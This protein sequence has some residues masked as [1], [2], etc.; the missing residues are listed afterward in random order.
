MSNV[1]QF[2]ERLGMDPK[3]LSAAEYAASVAALDV[4]EAQRRALLDR[5][6]HALSALLGGRGTMMCVVWPADEPAPQDDQPDGDQP[7]ED[8]PPEAE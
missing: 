6:P 5:D 8:V 7:A 3:C 4:D 2:I 1:V